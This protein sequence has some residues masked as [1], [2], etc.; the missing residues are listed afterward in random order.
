MILD[1]KCLFKSIHL[2]LE[3]FVR[4]SVWLNKRK[5]ILNTTTIF[6]FVSSRITPGESKTNGVNVSLFVKV[7]V[8]HECSNGNIYFPLTSMYV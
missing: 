3:S 6:L 5:R 8:T 1:E 4:C 7:S 2:S